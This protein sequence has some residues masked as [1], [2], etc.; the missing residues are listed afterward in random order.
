M[1]TR[2]YLIRGAVRE[3]ALPPTRDI[4]VTDVRRLI[5]ASA[6]EAGV[7]EIEA[8]SDDVV[9]VELENGFVLWTRAD[10]LIRERG[11]KS[12]SR[13]GGEGWEIDPRPPSSVHGST[14][15][16]LGLG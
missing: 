11:R 10:E 14:R 4:A 15:G 12:V 8:R 13:D 2:N 7:G 1:T 3:A 5:P 9:R 6:R 16:W